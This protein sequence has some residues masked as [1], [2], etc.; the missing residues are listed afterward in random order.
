MILLHE[1][2]DLWVRLAFQPHH[3]ALLKLIRLGKGAEECNDSRLKQPYS[4][5][6]KNGR[7]LLVLATGDEEAL[8]WLRDCSDMSLHHHIQSLR[9]PTVL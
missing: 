2:S 7:G 1:E 3:R 9:W 4:F 8:L 6:T 5:A